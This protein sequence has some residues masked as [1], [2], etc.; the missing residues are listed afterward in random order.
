MTAE[1]KGL[2]GSEY[3]ADQSALPARQDGR[4]CS[5]PIPWACWGPA[6]NFTIAGTARLGLLD[7]ADRGRRQARAACFTPDPHPET[8]GFFRS[9]HFS[10]AKA[11]VP[12]ISFKSGNDLV[13]GGIARGEA[14]AQDYTTKRYHQPDDEWSPTWDF[15]GMA[16]D[17]ALLHMLGR[18]LANSRE[19][20]NVERR[21]RIP[22]DPRQ[23]RKR[24]G[25]RTGAAGEARRTRLSARLKMG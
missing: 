8:G 12:A 7:D 25:R 18:R 5:T 21:Q 20:P 10:F 4:A 6:R 9:D 2:L 14:L 15:T 24:P 1:E 3:Y 17:A 19:W 13:N 11:G 16:Q 23:I 22:R